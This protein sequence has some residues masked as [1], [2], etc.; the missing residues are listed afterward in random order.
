M[1]D[2]TLDLPD[3]ILKKLDIR[4]CSIH[5]KFNLSKEK[6]T[7]RILKAMD[8]PYFNILAHPTGRLINKRM[9]Y[10]IDIEE[11]MLKAKEKNCIME[12][13]CQPDR[14]DLN[15]RNCE[16]AKKIGI[17]IS[18]ATDAHDTQS[19]N[20]VKYGVNQAR[21]AWMNKGDVINTFKLKDLLELIKK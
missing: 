6:Q 13:N 12:I 11:I 20:Y 19:F 14:M 1:E 5:Y 18:I 15:E 3:D 8:N 16:L 4:V 10:E 21:R 9:P 2:G 17:K 7:Q